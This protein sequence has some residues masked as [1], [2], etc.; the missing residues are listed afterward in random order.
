M[1][2]CAVI[3][4]LVF[5]VMA[6]GQSD[7]VISI[8]PEKA[9]SLAIRNSP[10]IQLN[11]QRKELAREIKSAYFLWLYQI[12]EFTTLKQQLIFLADLERI[13]DIRYK[14][15]DIDLL[16][17]LTANTQLAELKTSLSI[18]ENGIEI[19]KNQ[20]KSLIFIDS[21]MIPS[22]TGLY[23]YK[24][25]KEPEKLITQDS[26]PFKNQPPAILKKKH[27]RKNPE[28]T[29][30]ET[31]Y[32]SFVKEKKIENLMLQLNNYF[33]KIQ[34]YKTYSLPRMNLLFETSE[35]RFKKEEIDYFEY[36]KLRSEAF[37]IKCEYLKTL[38]D[39]NQ[40]AIQL[41]YYAY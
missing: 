2:Q 1:R 29:E 6:Y 4:L 24:V 41:E 13:A 3:I 10:A 39:Y 34:Y 33:K 16:E 8:S 12:N 30:I 31:R 28:L 19:T 7:T 11:Y 9:I 20:L 38:N 22:D 27:T 40:T 35:T 23:M 17:K 15:G 36:S 37:K 14:N 26:L 18:L 21:D 5:S 25:N 32:N